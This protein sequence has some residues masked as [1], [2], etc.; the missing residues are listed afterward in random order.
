MITMVIRKRS[1]GRIT[2]TMRLGHCFR[3]CKRLVSSIDE[4]EDKEIG[5]KRDESK[6][7]EEIMTLV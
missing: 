3:C 7:G 6:E 4:Y 1:E 2:I 5:D